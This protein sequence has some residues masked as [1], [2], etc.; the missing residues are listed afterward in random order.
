MFFKRTKIKSFFIIGIVLSPPWVGVGS[1]LACQVCD[2]DIGDPEDF[3]SQ[4]KPK[5]GFYEPDNGNSAHP[6]RYK[7]FETS[8]IPDKKSPT[9]KDDQEQGSVVNKRVKPLKETQDPNGNSKK[10]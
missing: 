2:G 3:K 5:K 10:N 4:K 9:K 8:E 1:A 6:P 7:K